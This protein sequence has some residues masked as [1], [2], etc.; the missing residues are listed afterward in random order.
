MFE[1]GTGGT[2]PLWPSIK[3]S[4]IG[5]IYKGFCGFSSSESGKGMGI[6]GFNWGFVVVL[7]MFKIGFLFAS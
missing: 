1:K 2:R 7:E 4:D 5:V 3:P 6:K